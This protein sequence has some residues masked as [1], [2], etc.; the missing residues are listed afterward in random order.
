MASLCDHPPRPSV[1]SKMT[2]LRRPSA[3]AELAR[4][5]NEVPIR[6]ALFPIRKFLSKVVYSNRP[7]RISEGRQTLLVNPAD[8]AA[9]LAYSFDVFEASELEAVR[10]LLKPGSTLFD[11]GANIGYYTLKLAPFCGE[12]G[13]VYSFEPDPTNFAILSANVRRNGLNN[14]SLFNFAL[15]NR[16]GESALY[17]TMDN[18][19]D[20]SLAPRVGTARNSVV[21]CSRKLD[22]IADL[23]HRRPDVIKIDVQGYEEAVLE[24][25]SE[26]FKSWR[27]LPVLLTEFE[28][29][30]ILQ[31][32]GSPA[33]FLARLD[34]MGYV[35]TKISGG[36]P[37]AV[38]PAQF[39]RYPI[40]AGDSC[41]LLAIPRKID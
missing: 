22:S 33:G 37:E 20:Y 4:L 30:S 35:L 14:V 41:N 40:W 23:I 29:R 34:R 2:R 21:V 31:A 11:I 39:A 6:N 8:I 3:I 10:S 13:H 36:A 15:S 27:K 1:I 19:G 16:D 28:P 38:L 12:S 24:G 9:I 17:R 32:G 18:A 7:I 5:V 25:G 26:C